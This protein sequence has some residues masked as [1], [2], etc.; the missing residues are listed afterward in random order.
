GLSPSATAPLATSVRPPGEEL[1]AE[2]PAEFLPPHLYGAGG[3]AL[4][5]GMRLVQNL[6]EAPA[7]AIEAAVQSHGRFQTVVDLW[8]ASRVPVASLRALARADAFRSM[9]LDRRAALWEIRDLRDERLPLFEGE[10]DGGTQGRRDAVRKDE[11]SEGDGAEEPGAGTPRLTPELPPL[12]EDRHVLQDYATMGLSLRAHPVSFLRG[13]LDAA[14]V[15]PNGVL[16]DENAMP[17]GTPAAVAGIVLCRQRPGTASGIVFMTLEDETGIANL[18]I[19]PDV[20]KRHR[21]AARH[22]ACLLARGRVERQGEVVHVVV[23]EMEPL[24]PGRGNR[25]VVTSRDFH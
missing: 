9:G 13:Q 1:R 8:R 7:R 3:P 4:R 19:R 6:G 14:G 22:S 16:K 17:H 23:Q 11:G 25:L 5:L 2:A 10:R 15:T 18:I 24:E 20:Y 12:P 21:P